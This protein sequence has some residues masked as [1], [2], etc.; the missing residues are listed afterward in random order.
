VH[1]WLAGFHPKFAPDRVW[2]VLSEGE[3]LAI[4]KQL[5]ATFADRRDYT[6]LMVF[7][8]SGQRSA[9]MRNL[10]KEDIDLEAG[11]ARVRTKNG[12]DAP[13]VLPKPAV[14]ALQE[15]LPRLGSIDWLFPSTRDGEPLRQT[16]ICHRLQ[17]LARAAGITKR[18]WVHLLRHSAITHWLR[19]GMRVEI[20]QRQALHRNIATTLRY[21][22]V[23][24]RMVRDEMS[25]IFG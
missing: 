18:V 3:F 12:V 5:G 17:E 16:S 24:E 25:K 2:P 1:C 7:F 13:I 10:R 11:L 6:L 19:S 22:R 9:A 21:A 20:A 23:D 15:W 4:V 14:I 8:Y